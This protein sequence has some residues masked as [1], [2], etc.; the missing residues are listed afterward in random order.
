MNNWVNLHYISGNVSGLLDS[1][2]CGGFFILN[3]ILFP[4]YFMFLH[5]QCKTFFFWENEIHCEANYKYIFSF[6]HLKKRFPSIVP[7]SHF[8]CFIKL[9]RYLKLKYNISTPLMMENPVR[10]PIV[11]PIAD[12]MFSNLTVLSFMILSNVGVSKNILTNLTLSLHW[13]PQIIY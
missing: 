5:C 11:P 10:R 4:L 12:N 9:N 7:K 13:Y 8:F 3:I 2:T 1:L 6:N